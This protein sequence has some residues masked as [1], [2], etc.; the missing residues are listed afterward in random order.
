MY[1]INFWPILVSSIIAFGIGAIWYSPILFGKEWMALMKITDADV[2]GM[3]AAGTM[4]KSYLVQFIVTIVSFCVLAFAISLTGIGSAGDGA[5]IGFLA[6]L[7]FIVPKGIGDILWKKSTLKLFFIDNVN[8]LITM[9]IA[10]SIIG[11]W[12]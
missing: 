1:S 4:W 8:S 2:S 3:K 5:V 7:G 6:W 10:G 11:A 9:L 12:R